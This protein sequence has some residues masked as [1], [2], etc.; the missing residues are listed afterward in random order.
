M[1]YSAR[2]DISAPPNRVFAVLTDPS[3]LKL[4]T[5]EV[6]E[7]RREGELGVGAVH[8]ALVQEFGRRFPV[9]LIVTR[10]D[11]DTAIA[12]EMTTPMWTGNV[13]YLLKPQPR[14]TTLELLFQPAAPEGWKRIP[15]VLAAMA[16]RPVVQ[17]IQRKRLEALR[18]VVE[19]C[20]S[21]A[22]D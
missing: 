13:E 9:K 15:S 16:T 4:W 2:V 3:L 8:H 5:P 1:M 20:P 12:Y 21:P 10:Y 18:T 6:I 11:R 14:G 19:T 17:R 7:A 22:E